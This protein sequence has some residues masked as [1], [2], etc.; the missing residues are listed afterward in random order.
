MEGGLAGFSADPKKVGIFHAPNAGN[1]ANKRAN[2]LLNTNDD[3]RNA[4]APRNFTAS[5]LPRTKMLQKVVDFVFL[6][7]LACS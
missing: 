4:V 5:D 7:R 1:V 2:E 3:R 6:E